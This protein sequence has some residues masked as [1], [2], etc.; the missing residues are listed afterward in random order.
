MT[1]VSYEDAMKWL[2]FMKGN[3][4]PEEDDTHIIEYIQEVLW[5]DNDMRT[6]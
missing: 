4:S 5:R 6:S 1:D 3:Y 2:E